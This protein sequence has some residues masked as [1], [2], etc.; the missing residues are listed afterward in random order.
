MNKKCKYCP[1]WKCDTLK[2]ESCHDAI[3][4]VSGGT[5]GCLH[6]TG[7]VV[8]ITALVV[9]GDVE[10]KLQHPQSPWRLFRFWVIAEISIQS[11]V[12]SCHHGNPKAT[13]WYRTDNLW[14]EPID[15][16]KDLLLPLA[17]HPT[18]HPP[19]LPFLTPI[20]FRWYFLFVFYFEKWIHKL[21]LAMQVVISE[22]LVAE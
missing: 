6:G 21:K 3:F 8:R 2:I 15:G 11:I 14:R 7:N 13:N 22:K 4:G 12:V 9:I 5:V 19:H 20:L 17:Y 16:S 18:P 10:D 1:E